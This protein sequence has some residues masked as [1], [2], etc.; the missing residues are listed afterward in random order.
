MIEVRGITHSWGAFA[1]KNVSLS[2]DRGE[3]LVILGPCGAGKT[4]LL[5][6]IVGLPSLAS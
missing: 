6:S 3:Y 4:L 5:E 2:V 1:L